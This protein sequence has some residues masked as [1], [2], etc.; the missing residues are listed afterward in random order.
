MSDYFQKPGKPET[1]NNKGERAHARSAVESGCFAGGWLGWE[2]APCEWQGW[3]SGGVDCERVERLVSDDN[4]K[5]GR[6][7]EPY[8]ETKANDKPYEVLPLIAF[9][10]GLSEK[11]QK[12][13]SVYFQALS[14]WSVFPLLLTIEEASLLTRVP[15]KTL[16][17]W[18]SQGKLKGVAKTNGKQ[19][20]FDR[21]ALL[22]MWRDE[23]TTKQTQTVQKG[24]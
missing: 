2:K 20:R 18:N 15:V 10:T 1:E 9:D 24:R 16:Y 6:D 19:L 12:F 21:D 5:R 11:T 22:R 13:N 23:K 3:V 4:W 8:T 14:D 7:R 17:K